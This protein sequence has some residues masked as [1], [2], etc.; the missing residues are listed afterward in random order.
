MSRARWILTAMLLAGM[1]TGCARCE[2]AADDAP[3]T[4]E[5]PS[6]NSRESRSTRPGSNGP[7]P[8][9][10]Q[11]PMAQDFAEHAA[12][13]VTDETYRAELAQIEQEIGPIDEGELDAEPRRRPVRERPRGQKAR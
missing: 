9:I 11:L 10:E 12:Q 2:D 13:R 1:V 8:T 4:A 6:T 7:V 5:G 3:G